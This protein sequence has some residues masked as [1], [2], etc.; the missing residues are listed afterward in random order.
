LHGE[1]GLATLIR[2]KL[3]Y[4]VQVLQEGNP[5]ITQA[6]PIDVASSGPSPEGAR[7]AVDE[8]VKVFH[9]TAIAPQAHSP[10]LAQKISKTSGVI[11]RRKAPLTGDRTIQA[12]RAV[13]TND[14]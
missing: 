1:R 11:G 12:P 5:F 7:P 2:V 9:S 8:A 6:T 13:K 3:D 4:S 10:A 14:E